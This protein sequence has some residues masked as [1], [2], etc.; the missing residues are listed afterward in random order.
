[1]NAAGADINVRLIDVTKRYRVR[2]GHK[3]VLDRV[4]LD[5]PRGRRVAVLAASEVSRI[6]SGSGVRQ[7]TSQFSLVPAR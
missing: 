6:T 3:T 4:T 2:N 1:M 5:F 7:P